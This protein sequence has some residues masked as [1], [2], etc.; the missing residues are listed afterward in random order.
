MSKNL[1]LPTELITLD[2]EGVRSKLANFNLSNTHLVFDFDRTMTTRNEGSHGDATTWDILA[3][4]LPEEGRAQ[5]RSYFEK[6]RALEINQTMT[7]ADAIE[8]WS[9][10]LNLF[11]E[12]NI[13]L[14]AVEDDFISKA[15]IRPGVADVFKFCVDNSIPTVILS[16]GILDVIEIWCR[17]Y[18]VNPSLILSTALIVDEEGTVLGWDKDS[19]V[20]TLNKSEAQHTELETIRSN[21]PNTILIGDSLD[22][23]TMA[24]GQENVLRIRILDQ[25]DD[26]LRTQEVE[27]TISFTR[28][29]AV[30]SSGDLHPVLKL[31]NVISH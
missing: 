15:N 30:I 24:S 21:R 23:A 22:D 1:I 4:H 20:H 25:R 14:K 7:E 11:V 26:E 2:Q 19:L 6:Y 17:K 16:A 18:R 8:W 13:N 28:F 9:S 27:R 31:L 3:Q 5:H 29:D 12:Y 10:I